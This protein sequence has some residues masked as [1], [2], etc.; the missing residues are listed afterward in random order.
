VASG[1][2]L[3]AAVELFES[4]HVDGVVILDGGSPV[5]LIMKVHVYQLLGRAYGRELYLRRPV[6]VVASRRPLIVDHRT[7]LEEVSRLAMAREAKFLYDHIVVSRGGGLAGIV[8][9]QRL[10]AAITDV[11]VDAAR[12]ANPL[13]GLPGN[14][15]IE[16]ELRNRIRQSGRIA[17]MHIDLDDFKAFNDAYGFHRGDL[18]ITMTAELLHEE[19][20]ANAGP[21]FLGHIGGDDFLAIVDGDVAQSLAERLRGGF[22]QRIA[23]LYE[24]ADRR[25]GWISAIDRTGENEIFPLMTLS[26]AM[27]FVEPHDARH[28]AELLDAL[29]AAKRDTKS[30]KFRRLLVT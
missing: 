18:A 4:Q 16:R 29:S 22:V 28:Y 27:A 14:A 6:E 10:L 25:R 2:E 11:R 21:H 24:P 19:L 20:A 13:T 23:G 5:G 12:H 26:V 17:L 3:S 30:K 9:V 1:V 8:S 15:L 7:P